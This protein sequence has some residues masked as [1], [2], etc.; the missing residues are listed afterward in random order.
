M[1]AH[2]AGAYGAAV[3]GLVLV[4]PTTDPRAGSWPGLAR[5]WLRTAAHEDPRQVPRLVAQY[6]RTGLGSMARGMDAARR[7]DL[8]A[9]LEAL[10]G[11]RG[12]PVLVLRGRQDRICPQDWA[13]TLAAWC[14]TLAGGAH[15]VP[16]THGDAVALAVDR[17]MG[18]VPR[19]QR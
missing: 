4:G 16:T 14:V 5:R 15:M 19:A 1:A 3:A 13:E 17:F 12:L 2:A 18:V 8:P 10:R 11:E 7:D 9:V 6:R